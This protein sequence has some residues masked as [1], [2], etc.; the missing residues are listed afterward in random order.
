MNNQ[1]SIQT[2]TTSQELAAYTHS[3]PAH[4][5]QMVRDFRT[6]LQNA[7]LDYYRDFKRDGAVHRFP[8]GFNWEHEGWYVFY[9]MAGA[10]GDSMRGIYQSWSYNKERLQPHDIEIQVKQ[11]EGAKETAEKEIVTL[12]GKRAWQEYSVAISSVTT[13]GVKQLLDIGI[14][15]R[16]MLLSPILPEQGLTMI[17]APQGLGKSQVA[18]R[19]AYAVATGGS[20]FEGKWVSPHPHKVLV[21]DGAMLLSDLQRQLSQI[22]QNEGTVDLQDDDLRIITPD[23]HAGKIIDLSNPYAQRV[24]ENLLTDKKLLIIDNYSSPCQH[25][26]DNAST[27]WKRLEGWFRRL[28]HQGISVLLILTSNRGGKPRG[29]SYQEDVF[30]T[31]ISLRK[32][33]NYDPSAGARFEV[34]YD[35]ARNFQGND[36]IPFEAWLKNDDGKMFWQVKELEKVQLE[37]ILTLREQGFT[38]R[39]IAE[40]LGISRATLNRRLKELGKEDVDESL[41]RLKGLLDFCQKDKVLGA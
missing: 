3:S 20:M 7:G 38:Q 27:S 5:D 29:T 18:L 14:P 39:E 40:K 17:H 41:S 26:N 21:I 10:F 9:G 19:I 12:G 24:V 28:R 37:D 15:T 30:D 25:G 34:H 22:I 4:V 36:A 6:A 32:S 31:I 23:I 2:Q 35:K 16:Q 13:F 8:Y 1:T 11:I 33:P